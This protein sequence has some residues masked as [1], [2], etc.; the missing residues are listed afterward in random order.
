M[1]NS[2]RRPLAIGLIVVL[3]VLGSLSW[4]SP[5][6][7]PRP[8]N[9]GGGQAR[10]RWRLRAPLAAQG[11]RHR[12]GD[13]RAG[14][15]GPPPSRGDHPGEDRPQGERSPGDDHRP[16]DSRA[17]SGS[18]PSSSPRASPRSTRTCETTV[19]RGL[20]R[21][22]ACDR[23]RGGPPDKYFWVADQCPIHDD[24]A[25]NHRSAVQP[26]HSRA[27]TIITTTTAAEARTAGRRPTGWER[28]RSLRANAYIV[29]PA[30]PRT[31]PLADWE[32]A[33]KQA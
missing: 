31:E 15:A 3:A 33:S 32:N 19:A 29:L 25:P 27:T 9:R 18:R 5:G 30:A 6:H 4:R 28:R 20:L 21:E 24:R 8:A 14:Q 17:R 16:R 23:K 22:T 1:T 10:R 11:L 12:Q 13:L 2:T 7:R 26:L